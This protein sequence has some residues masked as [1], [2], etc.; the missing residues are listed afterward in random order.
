MKLRIILIILSLL[1]FASVSA[2][3]YLYHESLRQGALREAE[4]RGVSYTETMRNHVSLFLSENLKSVKALAGMREL[5]KALADP[6]VATIAEAN[7]ILDHF[8]NA[9]NA[10]VCYL[11][12][13]DGTTIASSNRNAPDSFVGENYAFRPYFKNALKGKPALYLALGI[14]SGKRGIYCS[15]PVYGEGSSA[16]LGVAVVK[17]SIDSMEREFGKAY[18]GI[19]ALVSPEGVVFLSNRE[20]WLYRFMW[21]PSPEQISQVALS[22]Q[23]GDGPWEWTGLSAMGETHASDL[24]GIEYVLHKAEIEHYPG[25]MIIYLQSMDRISRDVSLSFMKTTGFII[26]TICVSLGV[27]ILL[28]YKKASRLISQRK[29]AEKALGESEETALALLN[30]PTQ[31]ALLLDTSGRIL[32]L[33]KTAAERFGKP[34]QELIGRCAFEL[35]DPPIARTRKAHH[36]TVVLSGRPVRYEDKREGR[37]F[38]T[39]VYPVFDATGH[40]MRVA[41][42]SQDVTEQKEAEHALKSAKEELTLYSRELEKRVEKRTL[43]ISSILKYTPAVVYLK[44]RE[45]RYTLVNSRFEELFHISSEDIQ[46]KEDEHIFSREQAERWKDK[47]HEVLTQA[48]SFQVEVVLPQRDGLHTYLSVKFPLF[49]E[50]GAVSGL[51][52][53]ATDITALKKAQDQLRKLS[54]SMMSSQEKERMAIARELHDE[55]GQLLTALRIDLVW[56]WERLK[57]LDAV[58]AERA[59]TMCELI[60]RTIDEVR[61]MSIRLRP[62]VLDDLGLIPALDWYTSDFE[63]RTGT[64]CTFWHEGVDKVSDVL[65]TAVYRVAQEALTNVARHADARHVEVSI[66]REDGFLALSVVDDGKG[67][68]AQ[69]VSDSEGLGVAGMR[70]R[71]G[72]L[73]GFLEIQSESG[74]GTRV[75]FR[76][77]I[78]DVKGGIR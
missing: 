53:I 44:D 75:D 54:A 63:K 6:T 33:N 56:I 10:D 11:M 50:K 35:F 3:G 29:A 2:G 42:F 7:R 49:D 16:I 73:N 13:R 38:N 60:D 64:A 40:V 77:P 24:Q 39:H 12:S 30:A 67:F 47:D 36:E 28:L 57:R 55:L 46:G 70:E 27:L 66:R 74:K 72:L 41:I 76:V 21:K 59:L 62:G 43:E 18:E 5:R 15:Y 48:K 20:D 9:L 31:A 71:A 8:Q 68:H 61:G 26:L 34:P 45:N 14:T 65:A 51:C 37:W 52:G 19:A 23:F 4:R 1:A 32:A 78:H 17:A 58:A 22:R 69:D 25:W